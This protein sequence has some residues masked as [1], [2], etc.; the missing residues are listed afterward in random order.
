VRSLGERRDRLHRWT[1]RTLN[2]LVIAIVGL[3]L[4]ILL[5]R[6]LR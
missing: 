4:A 2:L 6:S 1:E 3:P 5:Y